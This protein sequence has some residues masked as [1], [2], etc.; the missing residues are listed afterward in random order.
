MQDRRTLRMHVLTSLGAD[1]GQVEELLHYNEMSFHGAAPEN[2]RFPLP[3]E[4][5]VEVWEEYAR[6]VL[7]S[8]SIEVLAKYLVQL[9]F[10]VLAGMSQNDDYVSA[11]RRGVSSVNMSA[12]S[13]L[14]LQFPGQCQLVL[15]QT[16]GG[17]IPIL[18]AGNRQDFVL[19]VQALAKHNEPAVVP[20][21]MGALILSGY[22]NWHRIQI[23][24]A[25]FEAAEAPEA[26][27]DEEFQKI[28]ANKELFQDRFI[29]LSSGPY[30]DVDASQI[31][32][33]PEQWRGLSLAIRREHECAHYF[34]RR[35]FGSM[36]NNLIDEMIADYWAIAV[37]LGAFRADWFLR[38]F[39]LEAPSQYRAG[40]RL[41][42][43]RGN[44]PL[45][46]GAFLILQELVRHAARNLEQF[47]RRCLRERQQADAQAAL[48][49]ALTA[50]TAEEIASEGGGILLSESFLRALHQCAELSS[51]ASSPRRVFA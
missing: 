32:L 18:I 19:L 27:W 30:S 20:A 22:N 39:G 36:R 41:Q 21:S 24:R 44:P 2:F 13:G 28:K 8:G 11:T 9:R 12:A 7:A 50:L 34:T 25:A 1:P 47:D 42:N 14:R 33:D 43:Y 48:F 37:T 10:P 26:S 17:R 15:H 35:T 49:M 46:D 23:L 51:S 4:P 3:D 31:G 6:E 40:G 45:T 5:F 29:I 16:P 38:F